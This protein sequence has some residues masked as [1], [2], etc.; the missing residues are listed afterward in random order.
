MWPII[1]RELW[2]AMRDPAVRALRLWVPV[3]GA[4]I[5]ALFLLV[6]MADPEMGGRGL[7]RI[8]VWVLVAMGIVQGGGWPQRPLRK[9]ASRAPCRCSSCAG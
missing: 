3:I 5:T 8:L 2:V 4:G 1:H 9:I 7:H 6:A